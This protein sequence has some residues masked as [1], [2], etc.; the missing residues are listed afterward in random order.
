MNI[1]P[2]H[3]MA[4][5]LNDA[6]SSMAKVTAGSYHELR[7]KHPQAFAIKRER[8]GFSGLVSL[9]GHEPD[10]YSAGAN[11]IE[12]EVCHGEKL[13]NPEA[14]RSEAGGEARAMDSIDACRDKADAGRVIGTC[15]ICL[16]PINPH[17]GCIPF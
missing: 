16:E 10:P 2:N 12:Q 11:E 7:S 6:A 8:G 9:P 17:C 15:T 5:R 3:L 13:E 4:C 14:D 1:I